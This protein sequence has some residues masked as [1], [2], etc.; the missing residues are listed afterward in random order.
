MSAADEKRETVIKRS[1]DVQKL[2]KQAIFSLHRGNDKEA[3]ERI[4]SAKKTA[5]ELLPLIAECPT[6]RPG[7]FANAVEEYAEALAFRCYLREGRLI[8][9]DEVELAEVEEYLGGWGGGGAGA[10]GASAGSPSRWGPSAAGGPPGAGRR[11]LTDCVAW[12]T[13]PPFHTLGPLLPCAGGVLDFT[14]ELGRL[15]IMQATA[16]DEAAVARAR[17]LVEAIMGQML[18]FD[19]RNGSLRKKWWAGGLLGRPGGG[20][21]H[22]ALG[23]PPSPWLF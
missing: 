22:G 3:D 15:A 7:S 17:D 8:R 10:P 21:R 13:P 23:C 12:G 9:R 16:R 20:E 6:L 19:L 14:G 11:S 5:E 2:S 18:Q 1:R 4:R